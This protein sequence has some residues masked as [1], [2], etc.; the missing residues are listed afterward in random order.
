M[1]NP[2]L[3]GLGYEPLGD[4]IDFLVPPVGIARAIGRKVDHYVNDKAQTAAT[5]A[6]HRVEAGV[7][8]AVGEAGKH[9]ATF[10]IGGLVVGA[11][12]GAIYLYR[13]GGE[14]S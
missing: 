6:E 9:A 14:R 4:V 2:P 5:L 11:L 3:Y 12:V 8:R 1:N 13:R 7:K 10:V